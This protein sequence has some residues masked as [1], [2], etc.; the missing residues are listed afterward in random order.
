[1]PTMDWHH[2]PLSESFTAFKARINLFF[3]DN[4]ITT[5]AKQATKIKI[6]LG[7]EGMRRIISSGLTEAQQKKPQDIFDLIESQVDGSSKINFRIHRLEFSR[8]SQGNDEPISQFVSRLRQKANKCEFEEAELNERL[9]ERIVISTPYDEFRR[10]LLAKAKGHPIASVIDRGREFEAIAASKASLQSMETTEVC[11]MKTKSKQCNNCG[12]RHPPRKCPA[13]KDRCRGCNNLGHWVEFCRKMNKEKRQPHSDQEE[14][15]SKYKKEYQKQHKQRKKQDAVR[16]TDSSDNSAEETYTDTYH[17][18]IIDDINNSAARK[19]AK[20][21]LKVEHK[22]PRVTGNIEVKVDTGAGGNTL[23]LRTYRQMFGKTPTHR[24]LKPEPHTRLT[25]YSGDTIKCL[26]SIQLS[27]RRKTQEHPRKHKFYV[28]DVKG[29]VIV[30]L[31]TCD[32]LGLVHITL[33]TVNNPHSQ[34]KMG[35]MKSIQDAKHFFPECFDKIGNFAGEET[36]HIKPDAVPHS[37]P[38][39]R[40]PIQL[41]EKIREELRSMESQGIIRKVSTHTDWCSSITYVTKKDGSLRICLDS[42]KLNESLKRCPHAIPTVEEIAPAFSKA[43]VFSKLDAKAGYWSIKLAKASQELTTFRTPF[44]RYCFQRLPFG[45]SVSQ[46]LFQQ[47]MDR[48]LE[49]CEG[50]VGIS[51][52]IIVFGETE[53]QHEERLVKFFQVARMEGLMLNSKKCTIKT[54]KVNFFGRIY[55]DKGIYQDPTKVEDILAMPTPQNKCELQ[56]F[57][58]AATFL[59]NHIPKFSEK[60]ALLRDLTKKDIPFQWEEDHQAMFESLKQHIAESTSLQYFDPEKEAILEVDASKKGLGAALIQENKPVFFASKAL[61]STQAN[62]GNI[63]RECLAVIHGIQ[64]F[65]HLLYGKHFTVITDHKPLE[66]IFRKPIH[67]APPQLQSM[68][69]KV[70]GYNFKVQYRPG[71]QMILADALSRLPNQAR[72][73]D[74]DLDVSVNILNFSDEKQSQLRS[75]TSRDPVMSSLVQMTYSGWPESIK[76]TPHATREYWNYRDQLAIE[77]GIL[78][79]GPQVIIPETM[80]EDIL[81][82]LHHGHQ[83]ID[84]TRYLARDSVFWPRI[85]KHIEAMCKSCTYCQELQPQQPKEPMI[86]HE[87]P[88]SPWQ[89]IGID[90]FEIKGHDYLIMSDYYSRY[91]VVEKLSNT[92]TYSVVKVV[93]ATFSMLGVPREIVSDNGPQFL[94]QFNKFCHQWGIKHTTSSPRYPQSNGFIER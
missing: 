48:I 58:G 35:A 36:L 42:K 19:E 23:P 15:V 26:G 24:L 91:P 34:G 61:T 18:I 77:N 71:T 89:K 85:N 87:K 11:A 39:R 10:E 20:T 93:K 44:G 83:G 1:M 54:N 3:E 64:R 2:E 32:D 75:E 94:T 55:S 69:V 37:D 22:S 57:L 31:P 56:S 63:A 9:I 50:C 46:D 53:K 29:P 79:K 84:K 40:C 16:C 47:H 25:S 38:P 92:T 49:Q 14:Q 81:K 66:T 30:G 4:D 82:Q 6:A 78:F 60:T 52:D 68:I 59:S 17:A 45:L 21:E 41:K 73:E 7:D 72:N 88:S 43:K 51:D 27:L 28:V 76:E 62:Y 86:M 8:I 65:H 80:R 70:M 13:Y 12:R 33:D 90:L 5:E 67:S 74:V